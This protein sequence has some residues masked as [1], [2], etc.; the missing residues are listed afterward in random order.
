M[1]I[2]DMDKPEDC[3]SCPF[4]HMTYAKIKDV[5]LASGQSIVLNE[6][7]MSETCPIKAEFKRAHGKLIDVAEAVK[8]YKFSSAGEE[9]TVMKFLG[10]ATAVLEAAEN[11]VQN[12]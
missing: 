2:I 6:D 8:T 12:G 7:R 3:E 11:E 1:I 4:Y 9:D 5:C 10:L